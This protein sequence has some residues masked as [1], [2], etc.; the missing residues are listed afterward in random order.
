MYLTAVATLLS[1]SFVFQV[2]PVESNGEVVPKNT[3]WGGV[4]KAIAFFFQY[5]LWEMLLVIC[6]PTLANSLLSSRQRME[7]EFI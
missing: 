6:L 3:E 1:L 7:R 5:T 2:L 4:C